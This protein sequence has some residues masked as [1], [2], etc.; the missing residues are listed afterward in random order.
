[1]ISLNALTIIYFK[2][3]DV[4]LCVHAHTVNVC[5]YGECMHIRWM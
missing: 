2:Y 1:M 4:Y 3:P 5:T